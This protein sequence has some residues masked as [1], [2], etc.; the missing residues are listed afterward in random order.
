MSKPPQ[1][2]T[3][4][5]TQADTYIEKVTGPAIGQQF[6]EGNQ[7]NYYA[8]PPRAD[9]FDP[10]AL[11][12][13]RRYLGHALSDVTEASLRFLPGGQGVSKEMKPPRLAEVYIALETK[14]DRLV[15]PDDAEAPDPERRETG[16]GD[17]PAVLAVERVAEDARLVLL[18]APGSGKSTFL[19]HLSLC[20]A[21][22][23]LEPTLGWLERLAPPPE[24]DEDKTGRRFVWPPMLAEHVPVFV[25]LRK[26]ADELSQSPPRNP[27]QP[28]CERLWNFMVRQIAAGNPGDVAPALMAAIDA[29][30][31]IVF[32]DGFDEVPSDSL[33]RFVSRTVSKFTE[34]RFSLSRFVVT[35]RTVSY[36]DAAWRLT[37]FR[38]AEVA[39]LDPPKVRRFVRR[40]Y[41]ELADRKRIAADV[42]GQRILSLTQALSEREELREMA[43][44]P[45]L[46]SLMA[47]LHVKMKLPPERAALFE[48]FVEELLFAYE[49][50]KGRDDKGRVEPGL[51][52]L[53]DQAET[54]RPSFRS[55]LS[56]L[57]F[58]AHRSGVKASGDTEQRTT[59]YIPQQT[60]HDALAEL[61]PKLRWSAQERKA[62]AD[63]V[64]HLI[65]HRTGLLV[66][67]GS[68]LFGMAFKLQEFMAAVHR[69]DADA[70]EFETTA[71]L[72][73][74]DSGYWEEVVRL[75]AGYQ[76]HEKKS[77]SAARSLALSLCRL[78]AP[79]VAAAV[80]RAALASQI[81]REIGLNNVQRN[82]Q[83]M[84]CLQAVR[85]TLDQFGRKP[86]LPI[87][88]RAEAASA[89]GGLGVLPKGVGLRP[90]GWPDFDFDI[91]LPPGNFRLAENSR[92]AVIAESFRLAR[93]PVTV[94][95]YAAFVTAGG[96]EDDGSAAATERLLVW[97]GEAGL[98]WKREKRIVGPQDYDPVFQT[99]NHP[100]VGVSW[101][102][103]TA[104]CAWLTERLREKGEMGTNERISLPSEAQWEW[105]ARWNGETRVAD[106]RRYPWGGRDE[107]DLAERCNM[108]N[109]GLGHTSA[110]G[111][112]PTGQAGCGAMDLSGNV[113]E[114][115]ENRYNEAERYRVLRG[116][117]W[118]ND[119]PELLSCGSRLYDLPGNRGGR[120]GFRCVWVS[121]SAR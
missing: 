65:E 114:W 63:Q 1:G 50:N 99:P 106:D 62:W 51:S 3:A 120:I 21:Q 108:A 75:S 38:V 42:A 67:Q 16:R 7:I 60:L 20:L 73:E 41:D 31:A 26:F 78:Q 86:A 45:Y 6:I 85:E 76:A 27:D 28:D 61:P 53:L 14:T 74:D 22:H 89:R 35:C 52:D 8:A 81:L 102:E 49:E 34:G 11:V 24:E 64:I 84:E 111:L 47:Q 121:G 103:A 100:R 13:Y 46:L 37:G 93:Y 72:I 15:T 32:L 10:K 39:S 77:P 30:K 115:C 12:G 95:Q 87:R 112:F 90:D 91:E 107:K 105:A 117:S 109:T 9:G 83:G 17:L 25:E 94:E 19:R 18:G 55:V 88:Q 4:T 56:R 43:G 119:Y 59:I 80:R 70:F 110:V 116:G 98:K 79:S 66:A 33:K 82:A 71:E 101:H 96:Y 23:S 113:W 2:K 58:E 36:Q 97:W 68:H 92:D 104:F 5:P 54:S 69:C 40:F 118:L 29:G 48:K 57:A 44:N